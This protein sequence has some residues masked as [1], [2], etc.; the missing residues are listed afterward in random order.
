MIDSVLKIN[1]LKYKIKDLDEET[2][3]GNFMKYNC[4][5]VNYKWVIIQTVIFE[6]KSR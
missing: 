6:K 5:W 4:C 3:I 1:P 2:I